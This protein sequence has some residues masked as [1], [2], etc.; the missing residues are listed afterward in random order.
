ME[1][2]YRRNFTL[3]TNDCDRFGR[4]KP[5]AIL[6][7]MQDA[8]SAHCRELN[9]TR[10]DLAELG[11]FWAI[12]R[13]HVAV[14]TRLPRHGE[15]VTVETW[16]GQTS[17]VAFPRSTICCDSDGNELFRAV[18]L[19]VLMDMKTRALVLPGKSGIE[20]PGHTRSGELPAPGSMAPLHLEAQSQRPVVFSEL[21]GNGHMNNSHCADWMMDLLPSSFHRDHPV[22]DF[23]VSYLTEAREGEMLDLSYQLSP[24]GVFHLDANKQDSGHRVFSL[25]ARFL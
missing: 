5:S 15:T 16:P 10:E 14:T 24:E 7:L 11:L 13:Q 12:S 9:L 17:R 8:A 21:D 18:S 1:S 3:S 4:A 25:E 23:T 20:L 22:R 2:T 6:G 19:W